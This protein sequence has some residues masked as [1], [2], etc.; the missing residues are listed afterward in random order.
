MDEYLIQEFKNGNKQAGDDF[1]NKNIGLVNFAIGLYV[2]TSIEIDEIRALVNQAFAYTMQH[3]NKDISKFSTYFMINV[4]GHIHRHYRDYNHIIRPKRTDFELKKFISCA[5]L[6]Q[7]I[8]QSD[9]KDIFLADKFGYVDDYSQIYVDEIFNKVN[10]EEKFLFVM[11]HENDYSQFE[12]G[13]M[14]GISQVNASRKIAK[15]RAKLKIIAKE[16]C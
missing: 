4:K 7:P 14:M 9:N 12:I 16:V 10:E 11:Y 13:E 15:A 1:Y 3:F 8:Y 5:S 2:H 6:D